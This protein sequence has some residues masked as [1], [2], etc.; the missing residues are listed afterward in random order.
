MEEDIQFHNAIARASGNQV[1]PT[2]TPITTTM[3]RF[4][5]RSQVTTMQLPAP[6]VRPVF[7][8]LTPGTFPRRSLLVE[9]TSKGFFLSARIRPRSVAAHF[10]IA[11]YWM[12]RRAR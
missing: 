9:M 3:R 10:R 12:A 6:S 11:G 5:F 8:P 2:L 1:A 4:P 7:R